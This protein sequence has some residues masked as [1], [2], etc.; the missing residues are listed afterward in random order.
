M[1]ALA[2]HLQASARYCVRVLFVCSNFIYALH[3]CVCVRVS[4]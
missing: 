2:V 4:Q 1:G 3:V